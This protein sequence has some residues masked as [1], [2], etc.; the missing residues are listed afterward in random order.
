METT[1][2]WGPLQ[3]CVK[4][5]PRVYISVK[6]QLG[7]DLL[8][9]SDPTHTVGMAKNTT[10]EHGRPLADLGLWNRIASTLLCMQSQHRPKEC[11]IV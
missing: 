6:V 10:P 8:L 3:S 1:A 2:E 5:L 11:D 4:V 9:S 7:Y